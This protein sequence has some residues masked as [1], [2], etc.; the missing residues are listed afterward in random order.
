MIGIGSAHLVTLG[1]IWNMFDGPAGFIILILALLMFGSRLPDIARSL[2]RTVV[3]FKKG[4]KQ[5]TD[6]VNTAG[7]DQ[8][9]QKPATPLPSNPGQIKQVSST[10]DESDAP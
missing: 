3:E 7:Q 2:G 6:D 4:L 10:I 9:P 8:S 1:S 5:S